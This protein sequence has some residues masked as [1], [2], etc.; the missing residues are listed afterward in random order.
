[1]TRT[2]RLGLIVLLSISPVACRKDV[3]AA[4]T[5]T[6]PEYVA[7]IDDW[8]EGRVDKLRSETGWLSV[9]GLHWLSE[10]EQSF[11]SDPESDIVFPEKTAPKIGT[12]RLAEGQVT[13]VVEPGVEVKAAGEP[14]GELQL[15]TDETGEPTELELGSLLFYP[16]RRADRVG[17]RVKD[18]ESASIADFEG[19][20]RYPVDAAWRRVAIFERYDEVKTIKVPNVL[21]VVND[22]P[23]EGAVVFEVDGESYRIDAI[24]GGDGELFLIFG[25]TTNGK[26]TYGA[27]RFLYTDQPAADGKVVV[28][29]NRAYNPPCAFTPFA[30]C[31]LPPHQN[32]L[33]MAVRAG[34]KS[35]GKH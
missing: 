17:I 7:D 12:F 2:I 24:T 33:P 4:S 1:M 18:R 5:P 35:Y 32:E 10:G 26:E 22:E 28:D 11:G 34:E 31:P 14:V 15:A 21:G 16:I 25:D 30:T 8:H 13:I 19:I 23:C 9:V 20:E 3:P 29:F 6:N 27:G